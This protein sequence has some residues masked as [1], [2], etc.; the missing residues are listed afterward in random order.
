MLKQ[1][2]ESLKPDQDALFSKIAE[3]ITDDMLEEISRAD[4]GN[5][6]DEHL[7]ALRRLRNT[8]ELSAPFYWYP[9]E[10]LEL[11]RYIEPGD[12]LQWPAHRQERGHWIRTFVCAALLRALG[13]PWKYGGDAAVPAYNLI[14]IV[15]SIAELP[16]PLEAETIRFIAW[17]MLR[18]DLARCDGQ[19]VCFGVALLWLLLKSEQSPADV[20][21][22]RL[23]EWIVQREN[24]LHTDR[25]ST[26]DRWLLGVTQDPPPSPWESLGA[27]L[28]ALDLSGHRLQL[29][30]WVHFIGAELAGNSDEA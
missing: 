17:F 2:L 19:V 7:A 15:R 13:P 29:Q 5:D 10:V 20:E 6:A 23:S 27:G 24:E 25:P 3:H 1:F 12:S 16:V 4:Y 22:I 8:G 28:R 18:G 11:I 30:E 9:F 26:F 21:L 14:R